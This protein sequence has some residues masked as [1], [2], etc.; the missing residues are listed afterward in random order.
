MYLDRSAISIE[1]IEIDFK[2]TLVK[3]NLATFVYYVFRVTEIMH[4]KVYCL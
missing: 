2:N 4:G 1:Q 3:I